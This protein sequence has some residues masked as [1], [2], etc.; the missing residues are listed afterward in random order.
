[1]AA[2]LISHTSRFMGAYGITLWGNDIMWTFS[3]VI[4]PLIRTEAV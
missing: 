3:G 4:D 1:M 2:C